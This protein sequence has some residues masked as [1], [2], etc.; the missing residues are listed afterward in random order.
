MLYLVLYAIFALCA[1]ALTLRHHAYP[2]AGDSWWYVFYAFRF[3]INGL[4]YDFG[5]IRTYGYPLF[6]TPLT[7]ISGFSQERLFITASA[8]QSALYGAAALWVS[9]K[10]RLI[11]GCWSL[12]TLLTVLFN[13]VALALV[14][15]TLTDGL[16][17][18]LVIALTALALDLARPYRLWRTNFSI[19]AGAFIAA[20]A[21]MLR[22]GNLPVLIAWHLAMVLAIILAPQWR[23]VRRVLLI[24]SATALLVAGAVFWLPQAVYAARQYG[25][26]SM[27]PICQLGRFQTALGI[28]SWKYD[29]IMSADGAAPWYYISPLFS[30]AIKLDGSLRWYIDHPYLGLVTMLGHVFMSFNVFTPFTYIYDLHPGYGPV[31]RLM[32]WVLI[33]TGL[34]RLAQFAIW[35]GKSNA[36]HCM[37]ATRAN[38]LAF[39]TLGCLGT[40]ALNSVVAVETRFNLLPSSVLY[41]IAVECFV[42]W[43]LKKAV[44][45]RWAAA[46]VLGLGF[47]FTEIGYAADRLGQRENPSG[48]SLLEC[49]LTADQKAG[50]SAAETAS[51]YEADLAARREGM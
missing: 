28:L 1:T 44:I 33:T 6:L 18:T 43:Y 13:P 5:T 20:F 25:Q 37:I 24:T 16:S 51:R 8:V 3:R 21:M 30:G 46:A 47:M 50:V 2:S 11:G 31:L 48:L 42:S 10:M 9:V 7:Y 40:V 41:I 17:F 19:F 23:D 26:L 14:T 35:A 45:S 4:L 12:A 29:T 15:D 22:P 27:L 32:N 34:L 36:L 38:F 39:V 49:Y